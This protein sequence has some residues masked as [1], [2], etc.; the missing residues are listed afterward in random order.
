M[1][2]TPSHTPSRPAFS[3]AEAARDFPIRVLPFGRGGVGWVATHQRVLDVPDVFVDAR[4][5]A[6]D[7]WARHGLRSFYGIPVV[8]DG[9]LVAVLALTGRAPFRFSSDEQDLLENFCQQAGLA[10]RNAKL[11]AAERRAEALRAVTQ[12]ANAAGHDI[13]NPLTVILGRLELL[14][15]LADDPE[16]RRKLEAA[17][18]AAHCR[19]QF[20]GRSISR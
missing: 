4:I 11:F 8:L 1:S 13:N 18:G 5:V 20:P 9:T 6:R 7:W 10:I 19:Q 3:D 14:A 15:P 16:L 12:L 2:P 17:L